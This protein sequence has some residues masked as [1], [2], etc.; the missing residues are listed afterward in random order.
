MELRKPGTVRS[1]AFFY[2]LAPWRPAWGSRGSTERAAAF[3]V[4]RFINTVAFS[5]RC[6]PLRCVARRLNTTTGFALLAPCGPGASTASVRHR[7][8]EPGYEA[9][10]CRFESC[11]EHHCSG[12]LAQSAG[13]LTFNQEIPGSSPGEPT[14]IRSTIDGV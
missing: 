10:G 11:R 9:A 14:M 5:R 2:G 1:P 8:Y 12:F 13:H 3:K 6:I 4:A 7:I